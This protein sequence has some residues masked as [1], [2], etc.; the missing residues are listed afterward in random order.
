MR[1]KLYSIMTVK[2]NK[3]FISELNLNLLVRDCFDVILSEVFSIGK[4]V[5]RAFV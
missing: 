4:N 3:F 5:V 1:N 2:V